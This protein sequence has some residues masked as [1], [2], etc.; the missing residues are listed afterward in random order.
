MT[1][2]RILVNDDDMRSLLTRGLVKEG[3]GVRAVGPGTGTGALEQAP[4]RRA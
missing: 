3:F 4:A 2:H 1:A